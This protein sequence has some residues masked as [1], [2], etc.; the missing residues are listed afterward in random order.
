MQHTCLGSSNQALV[1]LRLRAHGKPTFRT[2]RTSA[3]V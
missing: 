1:A 3:F 2:D